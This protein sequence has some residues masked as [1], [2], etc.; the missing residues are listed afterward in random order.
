MKN[1]QKAGETLAEV[2]NENV[3][4][5]YPVFAE[6][7]NPATQGK[8]FNPVELFPASGYTLDR[9]LH[10]CRKEAPAPTRMVC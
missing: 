5:N 2:W 9:F 3:I 1:F 8:H 10:T 7:I 4:D 6:Y